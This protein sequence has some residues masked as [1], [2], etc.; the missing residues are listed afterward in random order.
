M[1][2][3]LYTPPPQT[4]PTNSICKTPPAPTEKPRPKFQTK[5]IK[6]SPATQTSSRRNPPPAT[7][8]SS[9]RNPPTLPNRPHR[10]I[11]CNICARP[12]SIPPKIP[13]A[14]R[15]RHR[16]KESARTKPTKQTKPAPSDTTHP[17][18][19]SQSMPTRLEAIADMEAPPDE[20]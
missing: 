17:S 6:P 5:P 20:T 19:S 9:R 2:P 10:Q 14:C 12:P 4:P 8:A 13:I 7:Q 11:S 15:R 1:H 16:K 18:G 3:F